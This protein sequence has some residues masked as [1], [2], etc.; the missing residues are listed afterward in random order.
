MGFGNLL[1]CAAK[2]GE[3]DKRVIRAEWGCRLS[4]GVPLERVRARARTHIHTHVSP[5]P[6]RFASASALPGPGCPWSQHGEGVFFIC[7]VRLQE[8]L[9]AGAGVAGMAIR[10]TPLLPSCAQ[11]QLSTSHW[12]RRTAR[13]QLLDKADWRLLLTMFLRIKDAIE[14]EMYH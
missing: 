4:A 9:R 3:W 8:V 2:G 10:D 13:Y 14:C 6:F 1:R 7:F 5:C 12:D 11:N